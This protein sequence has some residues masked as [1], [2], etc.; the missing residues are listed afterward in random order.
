MS[1]EIAECAFSELDT[2]L[3]RVFS[4]LLQDEEP[5]FCYQRKE[6]YGII[7]PTYSFYAWVITE[8]EIITL[9]SPV[10][11]EVDEFQIIYLDTI[12]KINEQRPS[13]GFYPIV[14]HDSNRELLSLPFENKQMAYTFTYK[15]RHAIRKAR[16]RG[17]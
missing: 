15:L 11:G 9:S 13:G 12:T 2:A 14:I 5:R 8:S 1:T 7:S 17:L 3:R 6:T 10:A 4:S 16:F